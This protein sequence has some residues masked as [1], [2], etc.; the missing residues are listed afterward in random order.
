MLFGDAD[1]VGLV[2]LTSA[3]CSRVSGDGEDDHSS[4]CRQF[5]TDRRSRTSAALRELLEAER[6]GE[7]GAA[8]ADVH[9]EMV[10]NTA[11]DVNP[12]RRRLSSH[13]KR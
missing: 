8:G 9:G 11:Q 3:G 4:E 10:A 2:E 1:R 6:G 12:S 13:L 7:D 5:V